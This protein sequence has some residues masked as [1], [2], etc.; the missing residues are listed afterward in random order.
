MLF[1]GL[2]LED[3]R[4]LK[5]LF[6]AAHVPW[7]EL[8]LLAVTISILYFI[9]SQTLLL[10][11]SELP[12]PFTVPIPEQAKEGWKGQEIGETS[13]KAGFCLCILESRV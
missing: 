7:T 8:T 2:Q 9:L 12:V 11:E 1:H 5:K 6:P 13:I 4:N 3:T 10:D